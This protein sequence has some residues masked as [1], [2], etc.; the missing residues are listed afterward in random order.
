MDRGI[1][2]LPKATDAARAEERDLSTHKNKEDQL[3]IISLQASNFLALKAV[4]VQAGPGPVI[5]ISGRNGQGKTSLLDSI[6]CALTGIMPAQPIREGCEKAAIKLELGDGSTPELTVSRIISQGIDGKFKATLKVEGPT[7]VYKSPQKMLDG[8]LGALSFD[9]LEFTRLA[10]K[11]QLGKLLALLNLD[12]T[13]Q[14][15]RR[16]ELYEERAFVNREVKNLEGQE[17]KFETVDAVMARSNLP[18][19]PM[20]VAKLMAESDAVNAKIARADAL[21]TRKTQLTERIIDLMA[22]LAQ[23]NAD[24]DNIELELATIDVKTKQNERSIIQNKIAEASKT[25]QAVAEE[26]ERQGLFKQRMAKQLE[27]KN[28]SDLIDGIDQAKETA[29][30]AAE[31]PIA[32]LSFDDN[33]LLFNGHPLAQIA[34]SEQIKVTLSMAMAMNPT[35]RVLRIKDGSLLDENSLK[36][37]EDMATE[38]DMQVW[39][40]V[41]SHGEPV[42]IVIEAGEVV[43]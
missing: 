18:A 8:L 30:A 19:E 28:L 40:E 34:S 43:T 29:I 23:T 17:A 22:K 6:Y 33:G 15:Q 39:I 21:E 9:P 13:A 5:T 7:S 35:L 14:D 27:S 3:K 41:I 16:K 26:K 38:R 2:L 10:P 4:E 32:G 31:M 12:F 36:V 37:I 20:D 24:I 1:Y 25:N 11:V 42:G